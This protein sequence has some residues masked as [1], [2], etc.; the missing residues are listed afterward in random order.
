MPDEHFG[1]A[2]AEMVRAG[3]VVFVPA[4]GG[5]PEI[6]GPEPALLF[7]SP[8]DAVQKIRAVLADA[9][10]RGRLRAHLETRAP[11]FGT[12]RFVARLRAIVDDQLSGATAIRRNSALSRMSSS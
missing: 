11:R 9:P 12:E 5:P 2:V 10:L 7:A 6:V 3:C 8:A 4:T 1:I